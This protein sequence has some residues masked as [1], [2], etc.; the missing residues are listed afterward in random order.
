MI[1]NPIEN[2]NA[3]LLSNVEL[4]IAT[5]SEFVLAPDRVEI[6]NN[7]FLSRGINAEKAMTYN[8]SGKSGNQKGKIAKNNA[9]R[10][11]ILAI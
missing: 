7:A 2:G 3:R 8:K 11:I 4:N 6:V 10:K 5:E 9:L 1:N